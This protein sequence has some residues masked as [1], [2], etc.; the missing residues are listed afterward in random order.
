VI[1]WQRL[2]LAAEIKR[3]R[4]VVSSLPD[5]Y[6]RASAVERKDL[7]AK[8]ENRGSPAAAVAKTKNVTLKDV[9]AA[10][11]VDPSVVSRVANS[12]P[13]LNIG[14][15]TRARVIQAIADL[16]YRTNQAARNLRLSR[17]FTLGLVL[18]NVSNPVYAPIV[19]GVMQ[20]AEAKGYAVVLGSQVGSTGALRSFAELLEHGRVDGMLVAT[21]SADDADVEKELVKDDRIL[22]VNR[23]S[24]VGGSVYVDDTAGSALATEHLIS[25][26]HRRIGHLA[27]P[28]TVETSGRRTAGFHAALDSAGIPRDPALIVE[29]TDFTAASGYAAARELLARSPRPSALFVANADAAIGAMRAAIELGIDIP[30]EL[31]VIAFHDSDLADFVTPPLAT[32]RMP[33][34][35]LGRMAAQLLIDR[36][37]GRSVGTDHLVEGRGELH[38][39]ASTSQA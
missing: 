18:P 1:G 13:A 36:I 15:A 17:N 6:P 22:V 3:L 10:A 24:G 39:R 21:G 38:P 30:R 29:M 19:Q 7:V 20:V 4:S 33:L 35:E 34:F 25:L 31:S 23:R 8:S 5:G 2:L 9:A 32:V 14:E 28:S 27:G 11:G 37:E 12:D 16:G 26:G